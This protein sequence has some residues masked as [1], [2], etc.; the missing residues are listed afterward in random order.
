[1]CFGCVCQKLYLTLELD[2][3]GWHSCF[4][5]VASVFESQQGN[6]FH[7]FFFSLN[8]QILGY[9]GTHWDTTPP[10]MLYLSQATPRH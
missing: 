9:C 1:M 5:Y 7:N 8:T 6:R 4:A 10:E 3:S 2:V